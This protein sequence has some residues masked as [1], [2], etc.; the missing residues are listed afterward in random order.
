MKSLKQ[1]GW[2]DFYENHLTAEDKNNFKIARVIAEHK[3]K[4]VLSTGTDEHRAKISGKF[5]YNAETQADIPVVGDWVLIRKDNQ[6]PCII[7]KILPRKTALTRRASLDRKSFKTNLKE[8]TVVSNIDKIF[9]VVSLNKNFNL[10]R[11]ERSLI[12][13]YNSGANPIILLSKSDL[14]DSVE[15]KLSLVQEI[16]FG[17]PILSF[18]NITLE[19]IDAI[20]SYIKEGETVCLIGSSG[21]GKTSL[22]NILCSRSEKTIEIRE[23]DDKGK[24]ATTS[25]SLYFLSNG[26]MIIDTPGLKEIGLWEDNIGFETTYSDIE[27]LASLCKFK[28]CTHKTEPECFIREAIEQGELD[29]RR[30]KNYLKMKKEQEFQDDKIGALQKKQNETKKISKLIKKMKKQ[31]T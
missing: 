3:N 25:R 6:E 11:I 22:I 9:I 5:F 30:F 12:F 26:G 23:K 29:E 4:F 2:N 24:H 10:S 21:V 27:K 18:S 31:Y 13:V 14:C 17:V 19:G 20:T 15:E 1:L 8:Q 7:E 28:N 16:A